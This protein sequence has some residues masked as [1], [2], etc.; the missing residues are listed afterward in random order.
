MMWEEISSVLVVDVSWFD[1]EESWLLG[2]EGEG[3]R[4]LYLGGVG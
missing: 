4:M 2:S 3:S 1:C